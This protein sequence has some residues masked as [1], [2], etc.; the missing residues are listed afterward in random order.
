MLTLKEDTMLG[1]VPDDWDGKPLRL[2]LNAN[3][4]GDWGEERGPQM[5]RVLRSTN[6]TSDG[7]LDLNDVALRALPLAKAALLAPR[8]HDILLERSGGGPGQPVG[9]V[10]FVDADM[11]DHGFSNFLHLLRPNTEQIDARFLGWVLHQINRTG[12]VVR[13]EQQTTQMR[14]LH[15][16]DYLSMPLPVPPHDEQVAIARILDAVDAALERIRV[17]VERAR[18]LKRACLRRVFH[19]ALGETAYADRPRKKLPRGWALVP[20]QRL[21]AEDPKNGLS[22]ESSAQPPGI[23]SFSI[24]AIRDGRVDLETREHF[25]Y[26]RVEGRYAERYRLRRGDVL[27]VRGNANPDLVGT[28]GMVDR[29]P[30]GCIYPDITM[31]LAFRTVGGP[32]V[33][34][35]FAVLAWNH[36]IVH[37]QVLRRAK[38]SN[39]TLKINSRDVNQIIMP[40]PPD[41][42]QAE[43]CSTVGAVDG[44]ID[45]LS[46]VG[47]A[48]QELKKSLM[49]DLLTGRVRVRDASKVAA[50]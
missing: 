23:P 44:L 25:K 14:N 38:T 10:G 1:D 8:K 19:D 15:L 35:A 48:Q 46:A 11:L 13:L 42:E 37:N 29:F 36:A 43:I 12:R 21:L 41:Q 17:A 16:R 50:S 2:L 31:R 34:G 9:R 26:A 4:P 33:S 20:T 32:T 6:L 47:R 27:V 49:H 30:D 3:Y 28:A 24:A 45:A 39:G 7:R 5:T 40:V 18:E 22:P